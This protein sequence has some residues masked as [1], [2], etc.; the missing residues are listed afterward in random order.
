VQKSWL[1]ECLCMIGSCGL[2][3]P[4][5]GGSR[6]LVAGRTGP[7][8]TTPQEAA[9]PKSNPM[10]PTIVSERKKTRSEIWRGCA[11]GD[12]RGSRPRPRNLPPHLK[13]DAMR[14]RRQ[15]NFNN[16]D[17]PAKRGPPAFASQDDRE[18]RSC[19]SPGATA[20][21]FVSAAL[22]STTRAPPEQ[23]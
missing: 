12:F 19:C 22:H 16:K 20:I 2:R 8:T 15:L 18:Q 1:I 10:R 5:A 13:R 14:D 6:R 17:P 23:T 3:N 11:C 4:T 7:A 9:R 21:D